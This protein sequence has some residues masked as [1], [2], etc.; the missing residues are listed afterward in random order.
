VIL[1]T[2]DVG[3]QQDDGIIGQKR[4]TASDFQRI[5]GILI[6]KQVLKITFRMP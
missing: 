3:C 4:N 1:V 2:S 6:K 5:S